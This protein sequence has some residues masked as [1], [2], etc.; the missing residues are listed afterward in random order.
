[1]IEKIKGHI[2]T[3]AAFTSTDATEIENFRIEYLGQKGLLKEFFAAFKEVPNEQKKE[4]GQVVN[5]LKNAT[6]EKVN[7]L[8]EALESSAETAGIYGDLSRPGAP[9]EIGSRHPI[10]LVKNNPNSW[11]PQK[12]RAYYFH[13]HPKD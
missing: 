10:S 9:I 11:N 3:V 8:K 2:A 1:M 6:Q 12:V 5:T 4:F 13:S 7:A